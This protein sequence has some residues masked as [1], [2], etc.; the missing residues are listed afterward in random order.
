[1]M[2]RI[3]VVEDE[4]IVSRDL[5]GRLKALG[6]AVAGAVSTGE[7]A[8][9]RAVRDRPDLVL[10]DIRLKGRMDG[11]EAAEKI[12]AQA[13]VPVVYLTAYADDAT[14]ARA[15]VTEPFGYILKPFEDRELHIAI[16]MALYKHRTDRRLRESERTSS[17][18]LNTTVDYAVLVDEA[19]AVINAN[20]KMVRRMGGSADALA[21]QQA[22]PLMPPDEQGEWKDRFARVMRTAAAQVFYTK[23]EGRF[24]ENSAYPIKDDRGRVVQVALFIHDIT[25]R[26]RAEEE[27]DNIFHL[28]LDLV[29]V[30]EIRTSKFRKINPAF[31]D[32]LGYTEEELLGRPYLEFL[33][34]DDVEPTKKVLSERLARGEEVV[35]FI[36]R[37]RCK[38]GTYRWLEWVSHPIK[39]SGLAYAI[40]RDITERRRAESTLKES[41]ERYRRVVEMSPDGI[42]L[43]INGMVVFANPAAEAIIGVKVPGE[44]VGKRLMDFVHPEYRKFV[45]ERVSTAIKSGRQLPLVQEKFLRLDGK[46]I[47]VEVAAAPMI[48]D[49]KVAV[50]VMFRDVSDR[51][52]AEEALR[53]SEEKYRTL[54]ESSNDFIF[55]VG[56]DMRVKYLNNFGARAFGRKPK[57]LIGKNIREMFPK[58]I[59]LRQRKNLKRVLDSGKPSYI[60]DRSSFPDG[61]RWLDTWLIPLRDKEGSVN[62]VLGVSRDVTKRRQME[63]AVKEGEHFLTGIFSSIQDGLSVLDRD[64]RIIKV[65]QKMLEWYRH[66]TPLIGKKC[67]EAYH[68]RSELCKACPSVRAMK[69]GEAATDVVPKRG[70]GG[71]VNGW[72]E[73]YSYPFYDAT[74]GRLNGV[75][76]YVRD[77]T[78][79][80]AAEDALL[81]S[82]SKYRTTINA[83]KDAIHVIGP[84]MRILLCNDAFVAWNRGLGLKADMVGKTFYEVFPFLPKSVRSEYRKVFRT[85]R[86]LL[87]E[88]TSIVG[89]REFIT[90]TRKIP[91]MEAG[92]V[93]RVLTIIRDVTESRTAQRQLLEVKS[94]LEAIL[95]GIS[96]S[97][98]VLDSRYNIVS[99]NR[100]F[101]KWVGKS[102][103]YCVGMKCFDVIHGHG[104]ACRSC[105]IRDVFRTGKPAES[106][107]YHQDEGGRVYHEVKAYPILGDGTVKEAIYVFKDVTDRERMKEQLRENY[108][109]IVKA[110]EEL[111]KLD[112]MKTEFLAIASHELRTP[113]AVIRGYADIL[114]SGSFGDL[115]QEQKSRLARINVTAEHL[116][117]IVN[118]ILDLTKMDAGELH[119]AKTR[120]SVRQLVLESVGDFNQLAAK[121]GIRL[122]PRVR[123]KSKLVAD[124][125][126]IKQ[127]LMN[128]IDNAL[129]FTQQ[130]GKVTVSADEKAGMLYISVS[131]TGIGIR[132][133]ELK[134]IF[135]SFYQVDSSIQRQYKGAGLGL[136]VCKRIAE[137]HG[138]SIKV[139][140]RLNS[141]TTML[142]HLPLKGA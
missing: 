36:N 22:F 48:L 61:D 40:A 33:H 132:R 91:V 125:G 59:Y 131:D 8:V 93:A 80:K 71:V 53:E 30:S 119:L 68:G 21:G 49:G 73:L 52:L 56:T 122:V 46:A 129:K 127:L 88:E 5:E 20:E 19:G 63:D 34:P 65:N 101:Q 37:Y 110:N 114:S 124:R 27:L 102:N 16:D 138:G 32:V 87:T 96:E 142:V 81:D 64:L 31:M 23:R 25:D 15:K 111:M 66:N 76:E 54:A 26:K 14:L 6:F 42:A 95:D 7:E 2:P 10:M 106:V 58:E 70:P 123:V 57:D 120:F 128:L 141:G 130:G 12:K 67:Y 55:T 51:H 90:E 43:H 9:A 136:A 47:D 74:T 118:N 121:N 3:L 60:E 113:L 99:Y 77:I 38:D 82:E 115:N 29:C 69:T 1:M 4:S 104:K 116:N 134:N 62:A 83:L 97:I 108:E 28:S 126:R 86:M 17:L 39:E 103:L 117:N 45:A 79:R 78:A 85:G 92:R 89:G 24:F 133:K 98:V 75:I 105:V 50:L 11:I 107:H 139:R 112:R 109:H 137:L 140:S 72:L 13:D 135:R 35:G 84:D 18:L 44:L 94:H 100:A 41:Q